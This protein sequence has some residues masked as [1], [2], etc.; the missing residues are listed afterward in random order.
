MNNKV[1]LEEIRNANKILGVD[2]LFV[3]DFKV[4]NF[5]DRRQD[6]LDLMIHYRNEIDPDLVLM[7]SKNDMHQD[8]QVIYQE[9]LRAFKKTTVLSYELP[10][11]M[12]H[13]D[14]QVF[15]GLSENNVEHKIM[16]CMEYESQKN[17]DYFSPQFFRSLAKTRGVQ[18]GKGYAEA[19]ECV[20]IFL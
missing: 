8:H 15:I 9:G 1:L 2:N 11:N 12:I 17:R 10:W 18:C 19:F 4:R 20:R 16:A 13:F 5:H 14:A 3:H 7:P 6:I